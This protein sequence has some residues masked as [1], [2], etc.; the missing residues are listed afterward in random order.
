VKPFLMLLVRKRQRLAR[1]MRVAD[2][3]NDGCALLGAHT[4]SLPTRWRP[5]GQAVPQLV[6][7]ARAALLSA[8]WAPPVLLRPSLRARTL[9]MG[10]T[11][12]PQSRRSVK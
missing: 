2:A 6:R 9:L 5:W 4:R 10:A 3:P 7:L 8:A 11:M 1:R 12:S